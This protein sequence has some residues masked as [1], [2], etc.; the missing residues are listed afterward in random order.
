[1]GE[2]ADDCIDAGMYE[3][4]PF[5][6]GRHKRYPDIKYA[7]YEYK[8]LVRETDRAWQL[9]M[10]GEWVKWFPKKYCTLILEQNLILIPVWLRDKIIASDR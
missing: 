4:Y 2:Y 10:N 3:E 9:E 5:G 6:Y 7:E 8:R 1:M